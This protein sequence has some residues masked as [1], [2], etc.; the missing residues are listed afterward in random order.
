[1]TDPDSRKNKKK[2]ITFTASSEGVERAERALKR[3]GFE[4]KTNFAE[5]Q[6]L[7]RT[8]VTRFFNFHPIQL[9]SFKRICKNLKLDWIEIAKIS[10]KGDVAVRS[11]CDDS[12]MI[13]PVDLRPMRQRK[14]TVLD[15]D[16][17]EVKVV[18]VLT[19]Q[20]NSDC[21]LQVIQSILRT[22]S[23]DTVQIIDIQEGSIRLIVG[24][25]QE[26]IERLLSHFRLGEIK[27]L[28]GFPVE[29]IQILSEN[30]EV[31]SKWCLVREIVSQPVKD[32]NLRGADL[33]DA[34]LSDADLR[35]ADLRGADLSDTDVRGADLRGADL[36]DADLRGADL[37]GADLSDTDV[38]G[39]HLEEANLRGANLEEANLLGANLKRVILQS[40][41]LQGA[42][43]LG[44]I[45]QGAILLGAILLGFILLEV[46]LLGVIL[47]RANRQRGI[48][49]ELLEDESVTPTNLRGADLEGAD[50]EGANL[51]GANL[52]GANLEEANVESA[53]FGNKIRMS[54]EMKADLIERGAIFND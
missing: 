24:G 29:N 30:D 46:I 9:D 19:G 6:L 28:D 54:K 27:E 37:R 38:S 43:L 34:D 44:V 13:E 2:K 39:T 1:M 4:S 53:Q 11:N 8:T 26:D 21:N 10:G 17:Q 49:E 5:S 47:E 25:S 3:L 31:S 16:S 41:I 36:S 42:I 12:E 48:L 51:R 20:I 40:S 50:L 23:G 14:I 52:R 7:S 32:R 45:L 15:R 35:G 33:S 22:Y 18:I